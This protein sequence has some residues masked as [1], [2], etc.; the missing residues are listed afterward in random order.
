MRP[1]KIN[2]LKPKKVKGRITM[3]RAIPYKG[4]N[5]YIR[6]IDKDIFEYLAVFKNE[7]YSSY[8]II[9][10]KKGATKL[11]K[12]EIQQAGALILN[13]AFATLDMLLGV[14]LSEEE[15]EK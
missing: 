13:G 1:R 4:N 15:I 9:K 7:I 12:D 2:R 8:L 5:V 3:L 14:K 11:T 10:P 6:M